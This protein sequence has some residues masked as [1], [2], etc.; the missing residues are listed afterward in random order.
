MDDARII[1]GIIIGYKTDIPEKSVLPE[2]IK[3]VQAHLGDLLI[4]VLMQSEE[5]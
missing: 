5:E 2:E 1:D 3:L 4:K